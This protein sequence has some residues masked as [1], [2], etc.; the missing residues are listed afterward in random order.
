VELKPIK[1]AISNYSSEYRAIVKSG[2]IE[3]EIYDGIS[4]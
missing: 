2:G 1:S 4:M 3:I